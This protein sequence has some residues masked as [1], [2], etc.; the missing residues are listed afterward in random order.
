M[1]EHRYALTPGRYVGASDLEDEDEP[2]E[3]RMPK[4]VLELKNQF[5]ES[6]SLEDLIRGNLRETGFDI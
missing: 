5:L 4:L 1:R 3:E 6:D 2:F